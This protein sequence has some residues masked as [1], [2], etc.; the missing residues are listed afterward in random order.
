MSIVVVVYFDKIMDINIYDEIFFGFINLNYESKVRDFFVFVCN[1]VVEIF[2]KI[3]YYVFTLDNMNFD[4]SFSSFR[5]FVDYSECT[6]LDRCEFVNGN[7]MFI[8]LED[9]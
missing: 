1:G 9:R 2:V 6:N 4:C 8:Y 7:K 5:I 3:F